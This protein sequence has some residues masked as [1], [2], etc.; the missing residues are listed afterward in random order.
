MEKGVFLVSCQLKNFEDHFIW[1]FTGVYTP[2]PIEERE[3]FWNE[4]SDIRGL[5]NDPQ[6]VGRDFNVVRFLGER[7]NCQRFLATIKCFFRGY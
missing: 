2:V 3:N 5:W 6:C 4:L 1:M 7:R